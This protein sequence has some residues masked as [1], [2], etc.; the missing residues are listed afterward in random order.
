MRPAPY[1]FR[2]KS[3][4][5]KRLR[6]FARAFVANGGKVG[7]AAEA[8]GYARD[9][10]SALMKREDMAGMI[11]AAASAHLAELSPRLVQVL[12]AIATDDENSPRDR[13]AAAN[14]LLDRGPINRRQEVEHEHKL[15]DP[16][17]LIAEVWE[18]RQARLTG[19]DAPQVIDVTPEAPDAS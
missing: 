12:L 9:S 6:A 8:A 15:T 14:S 2:Q 17:A 7:D 4:D 16:S 5:T 10:G 19:P 1:R 13:L 18:R 3:D 11:A